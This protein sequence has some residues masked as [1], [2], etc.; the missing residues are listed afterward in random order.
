MQAIW[1]HAYYMCGVWSRSRGSEQ[2]AKQSWWIHA[3]WKQKTAFSLM[4][5]THRE[6]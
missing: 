4:L 5:A 2:Q 1:I 6:N 3:P